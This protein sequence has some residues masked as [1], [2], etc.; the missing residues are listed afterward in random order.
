M[1]GERVQNNL[2]KRSATLVKSSALVQYRKLGVRDPPLRMI[3]VM[4]NIEIS[5]KSDHQAMSRVRH[6]QTVTI[7]SHIN[8]CITHTTISSSFLHQTWTSIITITSYSCNCNTTITIT[9]NITISTR[10]TASIVTGTETLIHQSIGHNFQD[11]NF[12]SLALPK[13][14]L[15]QITDFLQCAKEFSMKLVF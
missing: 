3:I 13:Y 14:L 11:W 7:L 12:G 5:I 15:D 2:R 10:T 6:G 1:I 8:V 4:V 9:P